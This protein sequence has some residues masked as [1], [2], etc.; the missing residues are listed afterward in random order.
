MRIWRSRCSSLVNDCP[1][2]VQKTMLGVSLL[3][4]PGGRVGPFEIRRHDN[5]CADWPEEG[6]VTML[7]VSLQDE[8]NAMD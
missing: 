6:P 2:Y 7:C 8:A 4:L 1:Q 3:C 5:N